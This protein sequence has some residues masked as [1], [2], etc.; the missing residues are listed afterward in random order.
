MGE[1]TILAEISLIQT[2]QDTAIVASILKTH[3][4]VNKCPW[5]I[6]EI[7]IYIASTCA[8]KIVTYICILFIHSIG[9][10]LFWQQTLLLWWSEEI[11]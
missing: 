9:F 1:T 5:I 4:K 2:I 6:G 3:L 7:F 8:Q 11:F 10:T